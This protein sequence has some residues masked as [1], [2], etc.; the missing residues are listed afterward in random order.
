VEVSVELSHQFVVHGCLLVVHSYDRL[1]VVV[2]NVVVSA[3]LVVSLRVVGRRVRP[4][5]VVLLPLVLLVHTAF[6]GL[7]HIREV[8]VIL[9]VRAEGASQKLLPGVLLRALLELTV[10]EARSSAYFLKVEVEAPLMEAMV[11]FRS[12]A[13]EEDQRLVEGVL[14]VE[15]IQA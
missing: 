7:V 9:V 6:L 2:H 12:R 15:V 8:D 3:E 13:L 10:V 5:S 14:L 4:V 1:P 11:D